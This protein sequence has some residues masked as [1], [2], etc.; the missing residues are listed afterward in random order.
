M[1]RYRGWGPLEPFDDEDY[2]DSHLDRPDYVQVLETPEQAAHVRNRYAALPRL[3]TE[4][5]ATS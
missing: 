3:R 2:D 4:V 1:W 5:A